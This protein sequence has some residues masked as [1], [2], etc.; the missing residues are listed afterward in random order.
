MG[1]LQ[2]GTVDPF[3]VLEMIGVVEETKSPHRAAAPGKNARGW[4][5]QDAR[6]ELR[7]AW[8][9][10]TV[11]TWPRSRHDAANEASQ[12]RVQIRCGL[13]LHLR[14]IASTPRRVSIVARLV[15]E[16]RL[17]LNHAHSRRPTASPE[18]PPPLALKQPA[19]GTDQ[20]L[21]VGEIACPRL[22]A[23]D[24]LNRPDQFFPC[25]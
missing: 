12:F 4:Q 14:G 22:D 15:R 7:G 20:T 2:K 1:R 11:C 16:R 13:Q 10:V 9:V 21:V 23:H 3:D 6:G 19:A 24:P 8:R 18:W 25:S 17:Y 5:T